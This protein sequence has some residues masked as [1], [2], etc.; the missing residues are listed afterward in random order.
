LIHCGGPFIHT[1]QNVIEACI[2]TNTHYLDITGEYQVFDLAQGYNEEAKKKGLM[3]MPGT[4]F[5]VV[6]SDCL[7]SHLKGKLPDAEELQLAFVSKGGR[8]S[9]GTTKTMIEN[10]G[11]SQVVRR[12]GKYDY[13][14]LGTSSQEINF[15]KFKHLAMGISWG[16]IS[17]AYYSTGI[18]NIEVFSG[19]D[20]DQLNKVKKMAK[21]SFLLKSRLV[22]N[23]LKSKL[24]KKPDGPSGEKREAS[25]MYLWGMVKNGGAKVEA[26]LTTP[27]GYTLTAKTAVLIAQKI[28]DGNF[29]AGYQTPSTAY[30]EGLILEVDGCQMY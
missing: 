16:D 27:N 14:V 8:L 13:Q 7:A 9:R 24:D 26:R 17:S 6:P 5:D 2:E 18:P 28:M 10:L 25:N 23:F 22:K 29:K 1:A 4:G 11:D 30:G 12:N 3:I 15:G 21:I 20:E 19:T